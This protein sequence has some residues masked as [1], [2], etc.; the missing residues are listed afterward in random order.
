MFTLLFGVVTLWS[1]FS[2]QRC[3]LFV[4]LR[5]VVVGLWTV[6]S[7][8]RGWVCLRKMVFEATSL[9]FILSYLLDSLINPTAWA[10]RIGVPWLC[11]SLIDPYSL[12]NHAQLRGG[13]V[14]ERLMST[15]A[16]GWV[17]R[18]NDVAGCGA[19]SSLKDKYS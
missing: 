13:S 4:L 19:S 16:Y 10:S 2:S 14:A 15:L 3:E 11:V 7:R 1:S 8:I 17:E 9:A 6:K 12:R 18:C 5:D